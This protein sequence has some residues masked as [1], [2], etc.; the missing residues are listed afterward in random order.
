MRRYTIVHDPE[1]RLDC[2]RCG[3]PLAHAVQFVLD[4]ELVTVG[5]ECAKHYGITWTAKIG[6]LADDPETYRLAVECHRQHGANWRT[7]Y[8]W[9]DGWQGIKEALGTEAWWRAAKEAAR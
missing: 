7:G 3:R 6:P 1:F 9:P 2:A 5:R 8:Q 4:G